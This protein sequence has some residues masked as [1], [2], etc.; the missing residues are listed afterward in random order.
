M[1]QPTTQPSALP[2]CRI[3]ATP[4]DFVVEE[5]PAYAPTGAGEH[6]FVRF[7][8]RDANTMD[9]VRA[10]ARALGC[11]PRAAG[12]AGMK[13]RR[14]VTTQSL[15]LQT[16]RGTTPSDLA[17][18]ALAL[19][20]DGITVHE[21]TPHPHKLKPGH[22]A[23][24][25][26]AITLRDLPADR[27]GEV[28]TAL[29]RIGREGVP[30]AFGAQRFGQRGDNPAR[31]LAWLRGDERPP[32]DPRVLRLHWSAL[33]S[34]VFNAV[35]DARVRDGTWAVPLLGDLLKLRSSGGLFGCADVQT[36]TARAAS[37][38]VSPTGPIVGARMRWPEGAPAELE[39][40]VT[41]EI[42]GADF[43]LAKTRSLGEG[44]RRALRLWVQDLRWERVEVGDEHAD[45]K[46]GACMRVYFVLPKGSYATTV[47]AAAAA[48]EEVRAVDGGG[49]PAD[50]EETDGAIAT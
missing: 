28:T 12:F 23:G 1:A 14:A 16:P 9:A 4:E 3:K 39:R 15:S 8:K 18:R 19:S 42:L 29:D 50:D 43:D 37:G 10:I 45:G 5:L 30:N 38:E 26:F 25:R 40:R 24:N 35:L 13:D 11:D 6:V 27:V 36:D 34:S 7:T 49:P 22:L 41:A 33:Q 31:A 21:A 47:L 32:R 20:L 17:A 2:L 44:T 48:L 46:P